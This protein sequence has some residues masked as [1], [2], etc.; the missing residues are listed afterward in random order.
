MRLLSHLVVC[1]GHS[2]RRIEI[3]LFIEDLRTC[4]FNFGVEYVFTYL[5]YENFL[6]ATSVRRKGSFVWHSKLPAL[7]NFSECSDAK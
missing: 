3:R 4:N 1:I 5:D 6:H 2:S 7:D